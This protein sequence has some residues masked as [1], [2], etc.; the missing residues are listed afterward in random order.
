[1]LPI[2][3]RRPSLAVVLAS[4]ALGVALVGTV[5]STDAAPSKKKASGTVVLSV[6]KAVGIEPGNLAEGKAK[7]PRGYSIIGGSYNIGGES[8]YAHA[9]D[10]SIQSKGDAY[11][12]IVVN[13]PAN[14]VLP[15]SGRPATLTVAANCAKTG[16]P[17]VPI[18]PYKQR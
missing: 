10:V 3:R 8:A 15:G 4:A 17:I 14:P 11:A 7:C 1:M 5:T 6:G 12:V 9:L 16:Y 13:P 2:P 18:T